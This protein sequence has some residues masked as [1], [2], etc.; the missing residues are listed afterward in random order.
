MYD[1]AIIGCG[2]IGAATAYELAKYHLQIVVLEKENDIGDVTTKANSAIIHAGYDAEEGTSMARLNVRGSFLAKEIAEKLSV[3]YRQ[4]GSLVVAFAKEEESHIQ[5]LYQRGI[6]NGVPGLTIL[7]KEETLAKEPNLSPSAVGALFA[8]S[9]AI[10]NP[11]EFAIAMAETASRNG[12]EFYVNHPVTKIE[13]TQ[14]GYRITTPKQTFEAKY[15]VNAAGLHA[16]TIHNMIAEPEYAIRPVRGEYYLLDKN[17]GNLVNTVVFQC[18]N[19]KGKGVLVSPTVHG[20]LIVGPNAD[21]IT[22]VDDV[23]TTSS[24]LASVRETA[25]LSVPGIAFQNSIRNFA[26]VRAYVDSSTDFIIQEAKTAKGFIDVAGI[27]SPGLSSAP[28]IGEEVTHLLESI[29]LP[30]KKKNT[31]CDTRHVVRMKEL[32]IEKQNEQ[33]AKNPLFGR[34]ICRCETITEGEIVACLHAPIAPATVDGV[35]KRCNAG[36][37]RCQ[38]GFCGPRIVEIISREL[39]IPM[40]QVLLNKEGTVILTGETKQGGNSNDAR[41]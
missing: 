8:P 11:W 14:E 1:V 38:G 3:P 41:I 36:M 17:Q 32:S 40:D 20:N 9:A 27:K 2:V 22:N 34:V 6:K 23:S 18:P 26:G 30:L 39:G 37:G 7:S 29:G 15:V 21:T 24:G 12:A 10:I 4:C 25:L 28:A 16:D 19:E 31:I 13:K 5:K 35:K 33:I